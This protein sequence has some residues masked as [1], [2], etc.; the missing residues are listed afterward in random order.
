MVFVSWQFQPNGNG[1]QVLQNVSI[2]NRSG[3][4][5]IN[6]SRIL[7]NNA[8]I[9]Q[10]IWFSNLKMNTFCICMFFIVIARASQKTKFEQLL[11]DLAFITD[12]M[13]DKELLHVKDSIDWDKIISDSSTKYTPPS[14]KVGI[15]CNYCVDCTG[16]MKMDE[17]PAICNECYVS[18][19]H[20]ICKTFTSLIWKEISS[21]QY[22]SMTDLV[23]FYY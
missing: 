18:W 3:F 17:S 14:L 20:I 16:L 22:E 12:E 11:D 23:Y 15:I 19:M 10:S 5:C 7:L 21:L 8:L 1:C 9:K 6:W 13:F 2:I 4:S